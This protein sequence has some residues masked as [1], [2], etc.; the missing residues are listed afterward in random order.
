MPIDL[1]NLF[2]TSLE[3]QSASIAHVI[4][5]R[6]LRKFHSDPPRTLKSG[7]GTSQVHI[8]IEKPE[9]YACSRIVTLHSAVWPTQRYRRWPF[10]TTAC[11][12][13]GRDERETVEKVS[14][15]HDIAHRR[16]R[17]T[18]FAFLDRSFSIT[19]LVT[20][21][22]SPRGRHNLKTRKFDMCLVAM[23]SCS[24]RA[25]RR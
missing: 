14:N 5:I 1:F 13:G 17:G 10:P 22:V 23:Q 2:L 15:V 20:R 4:T 19:T 11:Q 3:D 7:N 6:L 12:H 8:S 24:L 16:V 21:T 9:M 25:A 18:S